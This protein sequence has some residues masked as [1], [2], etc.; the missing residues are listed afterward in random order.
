[1]PP[2]ADITERLKSLFSRGRVE[3]ELDE[4]LLADTRYSRRALRRNYGFTFAVI[5]VFGICIGAGT[6]VFTV[7]NRVLLAGLPYPEP[8]RLVHVYQK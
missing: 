1:M 8:E 6:A 7:V 3:R 2:L 4:A 5:A